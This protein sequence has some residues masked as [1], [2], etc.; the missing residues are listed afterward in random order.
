VTVS[1]PGIYMH[2]G[3]F[4]DTRAEPRGEQ[5]E[6][7]SGHQSHGLLRLPDSKHP[8][9]YDDAMTSASLPSLNKYPP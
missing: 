7:G 3:C 4:T 1:S 6:D 5:H 8:A 9:L 2:V